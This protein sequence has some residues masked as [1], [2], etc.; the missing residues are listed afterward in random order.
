VPIPVPTPSTLFL[1]AGAAEG[2]TTQLLA[3]A[4]WDLPWEKES[5]LGRL[6]AYVEA[7]FGRWTTETGAGGSAWMTQVGVTPV[8]RLSPHEWSDWFVEA[9]I[10]ANVILPVYRSESKT[11]STEFNFGDHAA[12]GR[13]FGHAKQHELAV[14]IQ[15][16]SN[17]GINEPNPGEN[18]LQVRYSVRL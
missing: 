7:S 1:Q 9:G 4:T 16:F 18:F 13:R 14:R 2:R 6:G 8:L 12:L 10:G 5:P 3:G 11:F 17:G 15:H